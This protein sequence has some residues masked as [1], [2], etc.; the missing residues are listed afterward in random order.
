M[1]ARGGVA[2]TTRGVKGSG[3]R[4]CGKPRCVVGQAVWGGGVGQPG[5]GGGQVGWEGG[6]QTGVAKYNGYK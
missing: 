3:V 6:R 1:R 2:L 4:V 5:G